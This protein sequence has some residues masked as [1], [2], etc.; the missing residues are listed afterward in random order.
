MPQ[1]DSPFM[2][3]TRHCFEREKNANRQTKPRIQLFE[4][5]ILS[6]SERE[7]HSKTASAQRCT[8]TAKN[9]K[10][11]FDG[12]G[13]Q[14]GTTRFICFM[15]IVAGLRCPVQRAPIN[16]H[17]WKAIPTVYRQFRRRTSK[18]NFLCILQTAQ[19]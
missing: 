10:A 13:R 18:W 15:A 6:A 11:G 5:A 9:E 4:G 19:R 17:G 16:S 8:D 14:S 12:S 7:N 3:R 2:R 1:A